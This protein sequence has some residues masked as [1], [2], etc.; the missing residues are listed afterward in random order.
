MRAEKLLDNVLKK[1][2]LKS[3]LTRFF[4]AMFNEV[5]PSGPG[6]RMPELCFQVDLVASS[7]FELELMNQEKDFNLVNKYNTSFY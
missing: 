3:N 5:Q 7:N 4:G 2:S 6:T 1:L